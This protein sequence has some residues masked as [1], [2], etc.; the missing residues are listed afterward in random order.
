MTGETMLQFIAVPI[1]GAHF[2]FIETH[3]AMV[4]ICV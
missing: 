2:G 4:S 1:V 3:R